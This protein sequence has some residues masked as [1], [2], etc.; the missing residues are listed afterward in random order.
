M[1]KAVYAY[2][3][4]DYLW[5]QEQLGEE[6][7][8]GTFGENVTT[9]GIDISAAVVGQRWTL[10]DL[11]LEVTQPRLPC[12]KLGIRMDDVG[13]PDV[14]KSARRFGTYLRII[15]EGSIG[16]G[17]PIQVGPPPP[18]GLTITMIGDSYPVP[19]PEIVDIMLE[20]PRLPEGWR[21]WAERARARLD[22]SDA[23]S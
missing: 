11:I 6:V 14:F 13:F 9:R 2:A 5:W 18:H 10:P 17:D 12:F 7:G 4:E 19:H 16:A 20:V 23:T 1:D 21:S 22:R 3:S 15:E 8:A